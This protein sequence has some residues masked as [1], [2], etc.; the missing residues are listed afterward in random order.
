MENNIKRQHSP[1]FKTQ[2][3]LEV[4]KEEKTIGEIGS[5]FSVHPTQVRRWKD[6]ALLGLKG[7]FTDTSAKALAER[8]KLIDELYRQIGQLKVE[9]DW[10]KKKMGSSC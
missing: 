6:Q 2:V 10:L 5:R 4:F 1:E 8:D 9:L 3:V 7:V